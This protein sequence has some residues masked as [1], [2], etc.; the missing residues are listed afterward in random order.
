MSRLVSEPQIVTDATQ[1]TAVKWQ[2]CP[3]AESLL[4]TLLVLHLIG[5]LAWA[6]FLASESRLAG[7]AAAIG[8]VLVLHRYFFPSTHI[9]DD[10]GISVTTLFGTRRLAWNQINHVSHDAT[11][12]Y[13]STRSRRGS[14]GGRGLLLLLKD[15]QPEVLSAIAA[16]RQ[17]HS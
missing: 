7:L 4:K 17:A 8:V 2:S 13:V 16:R 6:T 9:V 5:G 1:T 14:D 11:R 12:V 3:A 15:N 10:A